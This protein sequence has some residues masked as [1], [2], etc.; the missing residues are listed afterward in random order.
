MYCGAEKRVETYV[1]PK[2]TSRRSGSTSAERG[3]SLPG[4]R[5]SAL[6]ER[7]SGRL[8]RKSCKPGHFAYRSYSS[9]GRREQVTHAPP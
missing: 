8:R 6:T 2:Q 7:I 1:H 3:F 9:T 4:S 5:N